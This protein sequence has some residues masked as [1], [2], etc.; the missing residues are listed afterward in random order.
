M[1]E[2]AFTA[3][4]D[5]FS[6]QAQ[7][8]ERWLIDHRDAMACV[9]LEI[10]LSG[11]IA[12]YEALDMADRKIR[13]FAARGE[14]VPDKGIWTL[15][16]KTFTQWLEA[17]RGLVAAIAACEAKQYKVEHAERFKELVAHAESVERAKTLRD[18]AALE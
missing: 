6:L 2:P 5:A 17:A 15:I 11:G 9:N 12:A 13:L 1:P 10:V 14:A 7:T 3:Q 18:T 4:V 16:S 8:Q